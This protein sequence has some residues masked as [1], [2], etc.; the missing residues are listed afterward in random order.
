M[1]RASLSASRFGASRVLTP[2]AHPAVCASTSASTFMALAIAVE[3][4]HDHI[5]QRHLVTESI[6]LCGI[7]QGTRSTHTVLSIHRVGE[8]LLTV[9]SSG[10][11]RVPIL[12]PTV[13][14]LTGDGN[15]SR[16]YAH[17]LSGLTRS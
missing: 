7:D 4:L 12:K 14:V 10:W 6:M 17:V 8:V 9:R 13:H 1:R 3:V 11:E 2:P 15:I 16:S 5:D